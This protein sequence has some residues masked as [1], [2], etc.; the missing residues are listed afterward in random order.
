MVGIAASSNAEIPRLARLEYPQL[1]LILQ[2]YYH[3]GTHGNMD[4]SGVSSLSDSE[5]KSSAPSDSSSWIPRIVV[6]VVAVA[7]LA[8]ATYLLYSRRGG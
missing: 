6:P 7:V 4:R 8:T 3:V 2:A 1:H 5:N